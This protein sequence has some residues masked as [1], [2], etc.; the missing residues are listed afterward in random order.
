MTRLKRYSIENYFPVG[1]LRAVFKGQ[2]P[3]SFTEV[4]EDESLE[5]QIGM[6]VK[7]KN[8]QLAEHTSLEDIAGTDL[9]KFLLK[10]G[11]ICA[12]S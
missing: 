1:A 4:K 7:N 12:E 6:N 8:R 9:H 10:I 11:Q 2:I 5:N 3:A